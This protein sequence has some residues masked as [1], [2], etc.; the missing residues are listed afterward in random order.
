MAQL[1]ICF[2][3]SLTAGFQSPTRTHPTGRDTPYGE[4]L[5]GWLGASSQVRV[6]GNC[7]ELT[8]E[9][10]MR[11]R[12]DVLAHRPGYVVI[13]GGTNDLGWNAKPSD[14]M[15]NLLTMYELSR[16]EQIIP[17]PVTVPSV[18]IEDAGGAP[19]AA[20]WIEDHLQRR[21]QLNELIL[22]Y[23]HSKQLIAVDLFTETA[24]PDTGRLA[25]SYSNDGLHLTTA[26][27][28]RFAELLFDRVFQRVC[29][30]APGR[31]T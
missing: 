25:A 8:S 10:A 31:G 17:V 4:F 6:S 12:Q 1:I 13:L 28:R 24:E 2:G 30:D 14:I 18:R 16:A 22:A 15:R 5:Q 21:R 3:D 7:G 20:A 29:P 19:D 9:M 27:Y 26:G 23:A 11:F